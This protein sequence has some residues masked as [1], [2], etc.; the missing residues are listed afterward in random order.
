MPRNVQDLCTDHF[1][2]DDIV[3]EQD[4]TKM[5]PRKKKYIIGLSCVGAFLVVLG[6]L[7]YFLASDWLLDYSTI[8]Y[9]TFSYNLGEDTATLVRLNVN[10]DYPEKLWVPRKVK[11]MRVTAIADEAFAGADE[12]KEVKMSD[13]IETIGTRAFYN[14]PNLESITFSNNLTSV[15]AYAFDGTKFLEDLPNE[16]ISQVNNILIKVGLDYFEDNSI[17]VNDENSSIPDEFK[18]CKTYYFRDIHAEGMEVPEIWMNGVFNSNEKLLYVEMPDY[19]DSVPAYGFAD[20]TNLK[21]IDFPSNIEVIEEYAFSGCTSLENA[22]IPTHVNEIGAYAFKDTPTKIPTDLSFLSSIGEG[23]FQNCSGVTSILYPAAEDG[24]GRIENYVFDGCTNLTNFEFVDEDVIGYIGTAA[25]RG[26]AITD[27]TVPKGVIQ[28]RDYVFSDCPNLTEISLYN[29]T[30]GTSHITDYHTVTYVDEE[31]DTEYEEI[32]P[33]YTDDGVV[34]IC[35]YSFYDSPNFSTIHLYDKDGVVTGDDGELHFPVTLTSLN[36]ANGSVRGHAFENTAVKSA[37]IPY[38]VG[39]LGQYNFANATSLESVT[40]ETSA[41]G[42]DYTNTIGEGCF[43]GDT[44]LTTIDHVPTTLD[45]LGASSF[46]GCSSLTSFDL[47]NTK[48]NIIYANTFRGCSSLT[49][50]GIS[51]STTLIYGGAYDGV[52]SLES[53][54][55][56]STVNRIYSGAFANETDENHTDKLKIYEERTESSLNGQINSSSIDTDFFDDTCELYVYAEYDEDGTL[57]EYEDHLTDISGYWEYDEETGNPKIVSPTV[58][59]G[60]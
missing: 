12:L 8:S 60:E 55:I 54:I 10:E 2:E 35:A 53:I 1:V 25:F 16:G 22:D 5:S 17:L 59:P 4:T 32:E 52:V 51:G 49:E 34:S 13:N 56:P 18:D 3:A 7:Y 20:C 6:V 38:G 40:F 36:N 11:G 37:T 46:D 27:F 19:L 24:I 33:V 29:N 48:V 23:A 30:T 39:T 31:Y 45:T 43:S 50:A 21:E 9:F 26:T 14:C 58:E 28:I 47:S 42:A 57:I 44:S 15:G 41:S